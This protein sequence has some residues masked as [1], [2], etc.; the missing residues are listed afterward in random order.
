[1][2]EPSSAVVA[3][4]GSWLLLGLLFGVLLW[5]YQALSELG[6]RLQRG[7]WLAPQPQPLLGCLLVFGATSLLVLLAWGPLAGGRGGGTASLLAL[8]RAPDSE[9]AG[10]EERWLQQ[11]SL[12]TQLRRLPLM[13]LTH[14]G[15]LAVG[16]ESPSVAL[17]ASVLLAIRRRWPGLQLLA[18]L[19]PQLVA[20]IGGAA[21]LGAAFRSP[22]LAVTYGL[23]ELGQH[24]G[25]PLVL[26][27]LLLAGSGTLVATT[28]GQPARLPG[29]ELG[30]LPPEVWGWATV[31]TLVGAAAGALLVRLLLPAA[32]AVK[33][34]L[35]KRRLVGTVLLA[36]SLTLLALASG[37]LSLNDGSLSLAAALSGDAV[38]PP[39][40]WL[41]RLLS[42]VLS[43][44]LGA[45]G[46][47]M[48]DSMTLGA[49]LISPLQGL[50]AL[51]SNA[52]AQ[53]AAV[54]ATAL[55]AGA[56]GCPLFCAAFVFTLQGDPGLLPLLLLVSAVAA[57]LGERW[58]GEGWN[59]H[60]VL[61][62]LDQNPSATPS[63]R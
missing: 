55:F 11:L 54:G 16:V 5:P 37:G 42:S 29:L 6:F 10:R 46:G 18:S 60:Q 49:L 15:G 41:W 56:H 32:A 53:L 40:I 34:L 33:R 51:D 17:G 30:P 61:G 63:S 50:P 62:L 2:T 31:L 35:A 22:L 24:R 1:M 25:L 4:L 28:M 52:L 58:R 8:D 13:L 7:L 12:A 23:E 59:D 14:L 26:P 38:G 43:L 27:A 36:S 9:R 21:G 47:L 45:P 3:P 44:A 19:S 39:A 20:V 48:H 57:A